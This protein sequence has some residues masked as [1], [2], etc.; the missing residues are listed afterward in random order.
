[1]A[2]QKKAGRYYSILLKQF[3]M[4]ELV[5]KAESKWLKIVFSLRLKNYQRPNISI[6]VWLKI[7]IRL[8]KSVTSFSVFHTEVNSEYWSQ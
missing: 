8:N 6:T 7:T 2:L 1:M 3:V 4:I 5:P